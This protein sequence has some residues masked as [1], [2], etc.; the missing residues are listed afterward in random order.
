MSFI[1]LGKLIIRYY[2]EYAGIINCQSKF[3]ALGLHNPRAMFPLFDSS[4]HCIVS[5]PYFKRR[6]LVFHVMLQYI[7]RSIYTEKMPNLFALQVGKHGRR[8]G[9]HK[10]VWA[11]ILSDSTVLNE[12]LLYLHVVYDASIAP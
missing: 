1:P 4:S 11:A 7:L 9:D 6:H 10:W 5:L 2:D 3:S 8:V 12:E